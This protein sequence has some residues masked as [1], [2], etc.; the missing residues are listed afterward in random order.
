MRSRSLVPAVDTITLRRERVH[1]CHRTFLSQPLRAPHGGGSRV[2]T[3]TTPRLGQHFD[4]CHLDVNIKRSVH[5]CGVGRTVQTRVD[6]LFGLDPR[7]SWRSCADAQANGSQSCRGHRELAWTSAL[8]YR[9]ALT[10][11]KERL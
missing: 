4:N 2:P 1:R 8:Q 3:L 6:H 7:K 9:H 10:R 11:V 5:V